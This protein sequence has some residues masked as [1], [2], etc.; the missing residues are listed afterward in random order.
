MLKDGDILVSVNLG[1]IDPAGPHNYNMALRFTGPTAS[2]D[3]CRVVGILC[4]AV[5]RM[6]SEA[7][8]LAGPV[9]PCDCG[10]NPFRL[11]PLPAAV[12][13]DVPPDQG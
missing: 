6:R 1:I 11:S 3:A 13:P 5:E 12:S 8:R 10:C 9:V 4:D 7:A 2:A